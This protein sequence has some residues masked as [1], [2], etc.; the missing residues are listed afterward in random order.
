MEENLVENTLE[1]IV[2]RTDV[3]RKVTKIPNHSKLYQIFEIHYI[4]N[5]KILSFKTK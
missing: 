4:M 1:K 2:V 3:D 5:C